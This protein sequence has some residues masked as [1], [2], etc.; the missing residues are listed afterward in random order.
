MRSK[1]YIPIVLL[2]LLFGLNLYLGIL[3]KSHLSFVKHMAFAAVYLILGILLIS[4]FRF[5][6]WIGVLTILVIMLIYPVIID[7]ES[8]NPWWYRILA[9]VNAICG[10]ILIWIKS[11]S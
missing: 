7:V 9:V 5:A 8:L 11:I 6:E 3:T 1:P 4:R 10:F 2:L